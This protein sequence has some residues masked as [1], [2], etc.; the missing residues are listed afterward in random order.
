[1]RPFTRLVCACIVA[2]MASC[3]IAQ[4]EDCSGSPACLA[5]CL[6]QGYTSSN[7]TCKNGAPSCECTGGSQPP[8]ST[9]DGTVTVPVPGGTVTIVNAACRLQVSTWRL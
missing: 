4:G 7:Y 5:Q 2:V 3:S 6:A 8:T 9:G 1:M